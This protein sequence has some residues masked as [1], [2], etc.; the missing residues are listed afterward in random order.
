MILIQETFK[1]F[2]YYPKDL[3]IK[4]HKLVMWK[5]NKCGLVGKRTFRDCRD[6]CVNCRNKRLKKIYCCMDCGNRIVRQTAINGS[7]LCNKC[8]KKG[9]EGFSWITK[10]DLINLHYKQKKTIQEIAKSYKVCY[11]TI[12]K[13]CH[14]YNIKVKRYITKMPIEE[15]GKLF[16]NCLDC[17]K[18]LSRKNSKRCCKCFGIFNSGQNHVFYKGI[19]H[20]CVDC[21][22]KISDY[23]HKRCQPC[24]AKFFSG[25]NSCRFGKPPSNAKKIKYDKQWFRSSW[26]ANFAKWCNLSGIKWEYEPKA[27]PLKINGK[28]TTYTPDFYLPEFDLWIEIKGY[29]RGIQ[30]K[31]FNFVKKYFGVHLIALEEKQLKELSII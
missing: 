18:K 17:G 4:S 6:F 14:K 15:R 23:R 5:C 1:I 8:S 2:E 16:P 22:K 13:Y 26:E 28:D 24:S 3:S 9:I 11:A 10:N 27:F 30:K 12:S 21:S 20:Y 25:R 31:K 19:I 7:G 29:W